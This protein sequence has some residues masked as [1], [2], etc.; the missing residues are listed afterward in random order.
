MDSKTGLTERRNNIKGDFLVTVIDTRPKH[1]KDK[2]YMI[3]D[4][5]ILDAA[6][7]A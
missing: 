4:S 6:R 7:L 2:G 5:G 1:E 3:L